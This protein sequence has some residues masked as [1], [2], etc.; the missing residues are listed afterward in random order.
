MKTTRARFEDGIT[1]FEAKVRGASSGLFP[2]DARGA[3]YTGTPDLILIG[4]ALD[5]R[6]IRHMESEELGLL[7]CVVDCC[8]W[9]ALK[10]GFI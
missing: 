9:R 3:K 8:C 1:K 4:E 7:L 6:G 2:L 5:V 10:F